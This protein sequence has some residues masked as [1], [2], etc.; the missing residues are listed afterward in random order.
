MII[1]VYSIS[2]FIQDLQLH[3]MLLHPREIE[4]QK[5]LLLDQLSNQQHVFHKLG[6]LRMTPYK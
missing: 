2:A 1:V 5:A 3:I 4:H 6:K